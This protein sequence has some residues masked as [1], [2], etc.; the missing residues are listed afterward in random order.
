MYVLCPEYGVILPTLSTA[1]GAIIQL[2]FPPPYR[3]VDFLLE[4]LHNSASAPR[5][6]PSPQ[7]RTCV[8]CPLVK[9]FPPDKH[10]HSTPL[11]RFTSR[12][13]HYVLGTLYNGIQS[14]H[15][16]LFPSIPP[17]IK[18][19]LGLNF[20]SLLFHHYYG[21]T[22][23]LTWSF[24]FLSC[25]RHPSLFSNATTHSHDLVVSGHASVTIG[26]KENT[27][28]SLY[29]ASSPQLL[30]SSVFPP[31]FP[32]NCRFLAVLMQPIVGVADSASCFVP[33][34]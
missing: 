12:D 34:K 26:F 22:S 31:Y 32:A 10:Q 18:A 5:R 9:S 11:V 17:S 7:T 30:I 25:G 16:S 4:I 23:G 14:A 33:C 21:I 2:S 24:D 1:T 20:V 6:M 27:Y 3:V 13:W 15:V 28:A 29:H 19:L 8:L